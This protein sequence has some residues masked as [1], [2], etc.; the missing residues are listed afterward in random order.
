MQITSVHTEWLELVESRQFKI[1]K[2]IW[3][4]FNLYVIT[5][6]L[7]FQFMR[8]RNIIINKS[9]ASIGFG[10]CRRYLCQDAGQQLRVGEPQAWGGI[11]E[12]RLQDANAGLFLCLAIKSNCLESS[13]LPGKRSGQFLELRNSQFDEVCSRAWAILL[14][15]QPP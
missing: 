2:G 8:P 6:M 12:C 5:H 4:Y 3:N 15:I 1:N 7:Y 14:Q 9:F 13:S 10:C 11:G